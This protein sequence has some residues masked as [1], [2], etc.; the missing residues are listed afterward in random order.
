MHKYGKWHPILQQPTNSQVPL[1]VGLEK[2][3]FIW[4]TVLAGH[5]SIAAL[6]LSPI[7]L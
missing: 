3:H 1:S 5:L 4:I 6:L 7:S 2:F